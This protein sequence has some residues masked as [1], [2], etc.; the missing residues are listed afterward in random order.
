MESPRWVH[1]H[2]LERVEDGSGCSKVENPPELSICQSVEDV[3]G[4]F[5]TQKI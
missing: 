3:A 4:D 5:E 1:E 2:L